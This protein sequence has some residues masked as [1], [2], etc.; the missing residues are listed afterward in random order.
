MINAD[1]L[2]A[3]WRAEAA[4]A[5]QLTPI[6]RFVNRL[7][8]E[9]ADTIILIRV[10]GEVGYKAFGPCAEVVSEM[11]NRGCPF[12]IEEGACCVPISHIHWVLTKL[13]AAGHRVLLAE[14]VG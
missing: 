4:R 6:E 11:G 8:E 7:R 14:D 3:R 9:H 1:A 13:A 2:D 10:G 12:P 5:A